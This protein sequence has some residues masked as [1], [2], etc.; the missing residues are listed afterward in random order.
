MAGLDKVVYLENRRFLPEVHHLRQHADDFPESKVE[1]RP[2]PQKVSNT[3]IKW[4]SVAHDRAKNPT[5]AGNVSKATGSK[6]CHCFML[7]HEFDRTTQVFPDMMH[8][9]KNVM[10]EFHSLFVGHG[11]SIKMRKVEN[12]LGRFGDACILPL[13][14]TNA[15]EESLTSKGKKW[16]H[17]CVYTL[18]SLHYLHKLPQIEIRT[19]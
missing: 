5:Q 13:P 6:G 1:T 15:T 9:L 14:E 10:A 4:N 18:C 8:V 2:C 17:S 11:D 12:T 3:E 19:D 7:L 16:F